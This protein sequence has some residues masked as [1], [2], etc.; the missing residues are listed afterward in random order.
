MRMVMMFGNVLK[1]RPERI[2]GMVLDAVKKKRGRPKKGS[3]DEQN[4]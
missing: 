1:F 3:N 4:K 2:L